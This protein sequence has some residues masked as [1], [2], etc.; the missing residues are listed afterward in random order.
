M[1]DES[2]IEV[3][4]SSQIE[5]HFLRITAHDP[6]GMDTVI[7]MMGRMGWLHP[8]SPI[9]FVPPTNPVPASPSQASETPPVTVSQEDVASVS[10][11]PKEPAETDTSKLFSSLAKRHVGNLRR[12]PHTK[13]S[14]ARDAHNAMTLFL[15]I[16]GDKPVGDITCDDMARF[17]DILLWWPKGGVDK[18]CYEGKGPDEIAKYVKKNKKTVKRLMLSTQRKHILYLDALF[19]WLVRCKDIPE[20]P[21]RYLDMKRYV[22]E[23]PRQKKAFSKTDIQTLFAPERTS[24]L[25]NPLHYFGSL[26][27]FYEGMRCNEIAQLH[28]DN[29]QLVEMTDE[30]GDVQTLPCIEI[31]DE[32]E[33]QSV[34][35]A[36]SR[37]WLPV[38]SKVI[39]AGFW[40]YVEDIRRMGSKEVFPGISWAGTGPGH[41]LSAWFNAEYMRK[42]CGI[43]VK[44]TTL[45]CFRHHLNTLSDRSRVPDGVMV[46]INGHSGGSDVRNRYYVNR[47]DVLECQRYLEKLPFPDLELPVYTS[48]RFK[49]YLTKW[50]LKKECLERRVQEGIPLPAKRGR[51]VKED[52]YDHP[53][54]AS[55]S[56]SDGTS[57]RKDGA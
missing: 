36:Y 37:R 5:L 46:S 24:K 30:N 20:N 17:A 49:P 32:D 14:S 43:N 53:V 13:E 57:V 7:D 2:K 41:V 42:E 16:I 45:H 9:Q 4:S 47:A 26:L 19:H 44:G 23:G 34:K 48:E 22:E 38:H 50:R 27:A 40:E 8:S 11:E 12:A 54:W 55:S 56:E 35:S 51:K 28:V 21:L 10:S 29:I 31:T 39:Q 6:K 3:N 52:W 18:P 33:A 15:R 25:Q 1:H